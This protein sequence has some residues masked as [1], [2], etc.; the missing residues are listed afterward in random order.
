[1]METAVEEIVKNIPKEK[2]VVEKA[3]IKE[4]LQQSVT[5]QEVCIFIHSK[6]I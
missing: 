4:D 5:I 3:G 6:I 2:P 1:M